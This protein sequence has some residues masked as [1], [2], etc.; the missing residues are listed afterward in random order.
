[1]NDEHK[2]LDERKPLSRIN[3]LF[4]SQFLIQSSI[5]FFFQKIND[6]NLNSSEHKFF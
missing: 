2:I 3:D 6:N 4:K 1:M 5:F